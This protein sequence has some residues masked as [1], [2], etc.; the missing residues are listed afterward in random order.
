M[1]CA[2][3]LALPI[4]FA[5]A[6][7]PP[8]APSGTTQQSLLEARRGFTTK[9]TRKVAAGDP[10][11]EPPARFFRNVKYPSPAGELA[12]YLSPSPRDGKK[13]PAIIWIFG[14]FDNSIGETAWEKGPPENDQSGRAFAD[15]GIIMMYPSLR[16]GNQNRALSK[17]FTVKLTIFS[18]RGSTSK[19][20]IT[21][22]QAGFIWEAIAPAAPWRCSWQPRPIASGLFSA[23]A[24]LK[25]CAATGRTIFLSTFPIARNWNCARHE[26]GCTPFT[27]PLSSWKERTGAAISHPSGPCR[28]PVEIR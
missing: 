27:A 18:P 21:S 10:V 12:A 25:M 5:T 8:A 2:L 9:L 26:N 14:G 3:W 7:D 1:K 20:R 13:H 15:A 6:C 4:C 16:G 23:S 24:L 19:N 22:T 28:G 17:A 11:P